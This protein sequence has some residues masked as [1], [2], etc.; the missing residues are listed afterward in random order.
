MPVPRL[1]EAAADPGE[2]WAHVL[3][4]L[5]G[6]TGPETR[7]ALLAELAGE[8]LEGA[9][10]ALTR[11][12][13]ALDGYGVDVLVRDRGRRWVLGIQGTLAFDADATG[14]IRGAADRLGTFGERVIS[15]AVTPDRAAPPAVEAARE[16]GRDVRHRSWLRVRDWVQERPERGNAQGVDLALLREA[17]YFLT[18]RVAELYRLEKLMAEVSQALRPAFAAMF[19]DLNDRSPAPLVAGGRSG[20]G[21]TRIAFPRTG[22]AAAVMGVEGG[23]LSLRLAEPGLWPGVDEPGGWSSLAVGQPTDYLRA[24]SVVLAAAGRLLQAPR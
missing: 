19:F 21:S 16:G 4:C 24:R 10:E 15:V 20:P 18:P 22:D 8:E 9:A 6:L 13:Q 11:E 7:P 17:E 12:R 3:A 2:Q 1:F 14:G 23:A 5:V